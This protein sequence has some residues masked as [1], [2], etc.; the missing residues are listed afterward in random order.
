MTF[1][2]GKSY[3]K[4]WLALDDDGTQSARVIAQQL[5]CSESLVRNYRKWQET[6]RWIEGRRRCARCT[7]YEDDERPIITAEREAILAEMIGGE[8]RE[9]EEGLCLWCWL[10]A[11]RIDPHAF[12]TS[13]AWKAVVKEPEPQLLRM[14]VDSVKETMCERNMTV[15]GIAETTG[16][17][18]QK[19]VRVIDYGWSEFESNLEL[20]ARE[21][22]ALCAYAGLD[23]MAFEEIGGNC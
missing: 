1:G 10:M 9:V 4:Q 22:E 5:G 3:K 16:V 23:A 19:M 21:V 8:L 6:Q 13:G 7:F 15:R 2:N 12:Y 20:T 14:L 18:M 11:Q 17:S